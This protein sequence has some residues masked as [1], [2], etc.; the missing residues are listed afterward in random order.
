MLM[1]ME[2]DSTVIFQ[3]NYAALTDPALRFIINEGGSRSS[4]TY[5][6]C[7]ML[8]VYCYQ[9]KNKV[10]SII[11]IPCTESYSDEGLSRDHERHGYL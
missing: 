11:D 2:I 6:L 9:N 8:I 4:K 3:K 5:S 1:P 10:V 7:Q